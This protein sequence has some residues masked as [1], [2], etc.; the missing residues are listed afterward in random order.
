MHVEDHPLEYGDFEGMIPPRKYGGGT[1][2][3]WDRG[4]WMPKGDPRADYRKGQ[5]KFDLVG[6]KLHGGYT[7]VRTTGASTATA[8]ENRLA[9]D[10]G[11][12]QIR[13]TR[14]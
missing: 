9:A 5:L 4:T 12:R 14:Q 2:L 11:K 7:L 6:D 3:L 13:A 1:V 8:T 10:Q